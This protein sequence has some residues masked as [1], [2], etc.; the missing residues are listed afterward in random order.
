MNAESVIRSFQKTKEAEELM[1]LTDEIKQNYPALGRVPF[2][3]RYGKGEGY[4]ETYPAWESGSHDDPNPTPGHH[5]IQIR[6][7][8]L[9]R[10]DLST[11][12][13]GESLHWMGGID[14]RTG[15]AVD[16]EFRKFKDQFINSLTSEQLAF[17]RMQYQSNDPRHGVQGR[18]FGD[19][20]EQSR[21]DAYLRG[22]LFPVGGENWREQGV[23]TSEQE[24]LLEQARTYLKGQK[25]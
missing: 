11:L 13:A 16:P 23:Y 17:E 9:S 25:K 8:D 4:A 15:Q 18:T 12:I 3:V 21:A 5:A 14:P 7:K 1:S 10:E 22:Y 20:F 19:W 24:T 6:R 2:S